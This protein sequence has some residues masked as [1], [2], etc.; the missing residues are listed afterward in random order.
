MKH[1]EL[2]EAILGRNK[3]VSIFKG[4]S[5]CTGVVEYSAYGKKG[6]CHWEIDNTQDVLSIRL[7]KYNDNSIFTLKD[8]VVELAAAVA[9][10]VA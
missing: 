3:Y 10:L 5:L 8:P 2:K 4:Q 1:I 9:I 7:C 6:I